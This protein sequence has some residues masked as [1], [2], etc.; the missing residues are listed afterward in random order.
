MSRGRNAGDVLV[1]REWRAGWRIV[2]G[3]ALGTGTGVVL[4]YFTF[5]LFVLP[6]MAELRISRGEIATVQALVIAGAIGA[7]IIGRLTDRFGFRVVYFAC[8]ACV[9]AIEIAIATI[10]DSYAGMMIAVLLLG[11]IGVGTT[12]LTATRPI[13]AWFD[14]HRG[15]ALGAMACGTAIAT[16]VAPPLLE[17]VIAARGWRAGYVALAALGAG[18]GVPA[19]YFLVH[20]EPPTPPV[21]P[22]ETGEA[23]RSFLRTRA[24]WLMA[25]SLIALNVAGAGFVGQ[26]SPMI[27]SEGLSARIAALGVSAFALGQMFG[28][29]SCGWCLD[30][31][32][33][34]VVAVILSVLPAT[35]FVLLWATES[36]VPLALAAA[37][38]IGFQQGADLDIFAFFTARRFG[39][40][41]YGTVYGALLGLS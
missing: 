1:D 13:N 16:I 18:V 31:F 8:M 9:I 25:L 39:I 38:L 17:A 35:G 15:L 26:L 12:A 2:L 20:G 3:C 5:S 23:D 40:A 29:L 14:T 4:L 6:I 22:V 19:V 11:L 37:F 24:F 32:N 33:P 30:R 41:R 21:E 27:Q 7:P 36:S 28:R 10:V 34:T